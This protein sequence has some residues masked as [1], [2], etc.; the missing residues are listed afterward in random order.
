MA[1][2]TKNITPPLPKLLRTMTPS[3]AS[4]LKPT[5]A[6]ALLPYA[7]VHID[8][9]VLYRIKSA[10]H[11]TSASLCHIVYRKVILRPEVPEKSEG[12]GPVGG[13]AWNVR[14]YRRRFPQRCKENFGSRILLLPTATDTSMLPQTSHWSA[15]SS[16]NGNSKTF[17]STTEHGHPR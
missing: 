16:H 7:G 6:L 11:A 15:Q 14:P 12:V 10:T 8:K 3:L 13:H 17:H 9:R 2:P 4:C 1:E 5:S